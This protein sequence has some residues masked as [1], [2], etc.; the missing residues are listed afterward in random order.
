MPFW[1]QRNWNNSVCL[2]QCYS[3]LHGNNFCWC[4]CWFK[5]EKHITGVLIFKKNIFSERYVEKNTDLQALLVQEIKE[6]SNK[7]EWEEGHQK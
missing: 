7:P 3:G 4:K 2:K 1:P 5:D 6:S